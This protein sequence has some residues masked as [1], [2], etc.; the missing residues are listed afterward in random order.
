MN[1]IQYQE[2][3][4]SI[5]Q[6]LSTH[7]ITQQ[8]Y[9]RALELLKNVESEYSKYIETQTTIN[10]NKNNTLNNI[11]KN[12]TSY[13]NEFETE[14]Q[15]TELETSI[16][17]TIFNNSIKQK[18]LE[19][20]NQQKLLEEQTHRQKQLLE[21]Q[22]IRRKKYEA[23]LQALE[24]ANINALELMNLS[25]NYNLD[26]L[27]SSYKKLAIQYHPDRPQGNKKHFQLIT[28]CYLTLLRIK[29][30]EESCKGFQDLK[31]GYQS[32]KEHK[33]NTEDEIREQLTSMFTNKNIS[34]SSKNNYRNENQYIDPNTQSF[35]LG[36]FNKLYEKNKLWDPNDDGYEEWFRS[37]PD[38]EDEQQ[39]PVLC[40]DKF[41]IDLFNTT[42]NSM[43][44]KSRNS[45]SITKYNEPQEL[46][47][48]KTPF[49]EIDNTEPIEDFSKPADAPGALQYSDLKK[50]FTGGC[51]LIN[52]NDI[53]P[54]EEYKTVED[55]QKARSNISYNMSP[56]DRDIYE[57]RKRE[58]E[59]V[60]AQRILRLK[61]L[62]E[63]QDEHYKSTHKKLI[64]YSSN[65]NY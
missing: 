53:E 8:Q 18:S 25:P 1:S 64:G 24:T 6:I 34:K 21:E 38:V 57:S 45:N 5:K 14:A 11:S 42:F 61:Y 47:C 16:Y 62:D 13:I 30:T 46:V 41:N 60:E 29:T 4:K 27:K 44:S 36:L 23:D 19:Q 35:N 10:Q 49:T 31:L 12:T 32:Y 59:K 39:Q 63:I 2:K 40:S 7:G 50:A 37:G 20:I 51:D 33:L 43:K 58:K 48:A 54:R 17:N 65:P 56:Q 15:I 3:I 55:L 9:I 28:K 26:E 22:K 52:P